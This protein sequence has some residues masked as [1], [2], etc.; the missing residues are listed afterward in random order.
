MARGGPEATAFSLRVPS[1]WL[2]DTYWGL[3]LIERFALIGSWDPIPGSA[4]SARRCARSQEGRHRKS[5]PQ[6]DRWLEACLRRRPSA[7]EFAKLAAV[8]NRGPGRG[9]RPF[10]AMVCVA[11]ARFSDSSAL[12]F[13]WSRSSLLFE[14]APCHG[15]HGWRV[16]LRMSWDGGVHFM[17][18]SV[19]GVR[20][21]PGTG[22]LLGEYVFLTK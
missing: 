3:S 9:K 5:L 4:T 6:G 8:H 7:C 12:C 14:R 10:Q 15:G 19:R 21:S 11:R 16:S 18:V 22:S 1:T 2:P 17:T 20:K 13:G